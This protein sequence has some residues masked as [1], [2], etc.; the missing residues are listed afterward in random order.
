MGSLRT[1]LRAVMKRSTLECKPLKEK[2]SL[3]FDASGNGGSISGSSPGKSVLQN[4]S[5]AAPGPMSS[6]GMDS[7]LETLSKT[8]PIDSSAVVASVLNDVR[9]VASKSSVCPPDMSKVRN[10]NWMSGFVSRGVRA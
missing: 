10:G 2:T 6:H 8:L 1:P 7:I 9:D 5:R 3:D 4:L